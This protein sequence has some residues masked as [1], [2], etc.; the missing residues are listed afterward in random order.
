MLE[1]NSPD[2]LVVL[3]RIIFLLSLLGIII[4]MYVLQSFLRQSSIFCLTGDG[5]S[6]VRKNPFSWPLGIPVPAVGLVGYTV[7]AVLAF[8]RTTA[9]NPKLLMSILGMATFGVVFVSWFT[10]TEIFLIKGICMW[11]TI[12]AV[13]MIIIFALAIKSYQL[14]KQKPR[15]YLED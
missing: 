5:C 3:N 9:G 15:K 12:S 10:Y 14:E 4:A 13:N 8:L 1:D 7:L 6:L 2:Q 11:C